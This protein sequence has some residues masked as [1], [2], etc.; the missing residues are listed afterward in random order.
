MNFVKR[1]AL[2][3]FLNWRNGNI[4]T[5]AYR[6][7]RVICHLIIDKVMFPKCFHFVNFPSKCFHFVK[8]SLNDK[9]IVNVQRI[10]T[11]RKIQDSFCFS[12]IFKDPFGWTLCNVTLFFLK[13]TF[14]TICSIMSIELRKCCKMSIFHVNV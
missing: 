7:K 6:L 13:L 12:L 10:N 9:N 11:L 14:C 1:H 5:N 3:L 8:S 4:L 2:S